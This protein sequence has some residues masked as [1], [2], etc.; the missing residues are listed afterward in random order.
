[1]IFLPVLSPPFVN[2]LAILP[3]QSE[4]NKISF[5]SN[6]IFSSPNQILFPLPFSTCEEGGP[7]FIEG[8]DE[9]REDARRA[10]EIKKLAPTVS[11]GDGWERRKGWG[12]EVLISKELIGFVRQQSPFIY[13]ESFVFNQHT[14]FK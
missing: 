9:D 4:E 11:V 12:S 2:I 10:G 6:S 7:E 3:A 5:K 13:F 14:I 1:M 8:P